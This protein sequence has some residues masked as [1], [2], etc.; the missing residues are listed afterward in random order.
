M[1]DLIETACHNALRA[2]HDTANNAHRNSHS[3]E[4]CLILA[5]ALQTM[6]DEGIGAGMWADC[7]D[8]LRRQAAPLRETTS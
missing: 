5:A 6:L 4:A 8:H 7:I 3:P 1:T 2:M